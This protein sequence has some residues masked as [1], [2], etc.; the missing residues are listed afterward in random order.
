MNDRLT[1]IPIPFPIVTP[2]PMIA[3][4]WVDFQFVTS[5][6]TYYRVTYEPDTLNKVVEV[7]TDLN[8]ALSDYQPALAVIVT[9]FEPRLHDETDQSGP[10]VVVSP[11]AKNKST[12]RYG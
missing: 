4:L 10:R 9:W 6:A 8:P 7:I 12:F 3:P 2:V 11:S 1:Y 5:G